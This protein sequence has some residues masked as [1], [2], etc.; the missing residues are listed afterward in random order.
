MSIQEDI[1]LAFTG[2]DVLQIEERLQQ[3]LSLVE[4]GVI[5]VAE[6]TDAGWVTNDGVRA[7]MLDHSSIMVTVPLSPSTAI[8]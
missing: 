5:R 4:S 1:E 3:V 6:K 2:G 8:I 7:Y